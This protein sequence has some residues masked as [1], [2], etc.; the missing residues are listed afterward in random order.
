[1]RALCDFAVRVAAE[2]SDVGE[3]DI[4]ALRVAGWSD[5]AIHD[6][7]QVVAYFNYVNR[8]ADG[9]GIDDEPEWTA[10]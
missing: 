8:I 3:G 7:L 10:R 1:V 4:D 9:V 5:A 6:A 2:P